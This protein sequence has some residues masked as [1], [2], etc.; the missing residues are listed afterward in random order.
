MQVPS[1]TKKSTALSYI[2]SIPLPRQM[3][4]SRP[5]RAMELSPYEVT[6]GFAGL[7]N[8]V[9]GEGDLVGRFRSHLLRVRLKSVREKRC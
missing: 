6:E 8:E 4:I 9:I 5:A 3:A 2:S 7:M 1:P